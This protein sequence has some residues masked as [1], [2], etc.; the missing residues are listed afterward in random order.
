[1]K[2]SGSG[3]KPLRT[4]ISENEEI[5]PMM[6]KAA[7]ISRLQKTYAD[8]IPA[9]LQH[10]NE[11]SRIAAVEGSTLVIA[12]ANGAVATSLKQMLPRL[13]EQF[14]KNAQSN[15]KFLKHQ[16]PEQEVTAIRLLVQ[17]EYFGADSTPKPLQ[18]ATIANTP[19]S[20][21]A[22]SK[23][24]NQLA[25]SPLKETLEKIQKR[26]ERALTTAKKPVKSEL[27]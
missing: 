7:L 15:Q 27:L 20:A 11:T 13:L 5:Q 16:T 21:D 22:L 18:R 1:M 17:P 9:N 26:R 10:L 19:M 23:L 24:T 4:L 3:F 14:Q 8:T 25:D 2:K 6:Q 12:V